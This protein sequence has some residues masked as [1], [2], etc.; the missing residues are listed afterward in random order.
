MAEQETQVTG[1]VKGQEGRDDRERF[2][3]LGFLKTYL[4]PVL[5]IF[6]IPGFSWWFF[7]YVQSDYDQEALESIKASLY[8][9]PNMPEEK[10]AAVLV[11]HE[12]MPLSKILSINDPVLDDFKSGINDSV[13]RDYFMFHWLIILSEICLYSGAGVF[14]IA[15]IA[16][17]LSFKSQ[18]IQYLSLSTGWHVLRFFSVLQV[19]GQ[20]CLALALSFWI[21]AFWFNMY[22]PK[23]I[24]IVGIFALCAIGLIIKA[25]FKKL[26]NDFIIKGVLLDDRRAEPLWRHIGRLADKLGTE[27]PQQIIAGID[28]NFFVTEQPVTV[29][30]RQ[31][32]GK[33][34]YLSLPLIKHM[35]KTEA[36]AVLAHELAHFSGRDTLYSKKISPLLG[37]YHYYLVALYE[38]GITRPVFSFMLFFRSLY[39]LSISQLSRSREYRADMLAAESTSPL[40]LAHALIK[41]SA[42]SNYRDKV[43]RGLFEKEH[44][45]HSLGIRELIAKGFESFVRTEISDSEINSTK[46]VHPFDSH[47]PIAQRI[48]AIGVES[49]SNYCEEILLK[50]VDDSWFNEIENAEE[51][52]NLQ[53]A[54]YEEAFSEYH[55][56]ALCYRFLPTTEAEKEIV[57]K[58]FPEVI[59]QT[60][61]D[62][63]LVINYESIHLTSWDSPVLYGSIKNCTKDNNY[64]D[65]GCTG[66][67]KRIKLSDLKGSQEEVLHMFEMYYGRYLQARSYQENKQKNHE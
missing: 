17:L 36:D 35:K 15:I 9:E 56:Q 16:V 50:P 40:D 25:I 29:E 5:M 53:W 12:K 37:R 2:T 39:Q 45:Q 32:F 65:I 31:Y 13:K 7:N 33:T 48:Q 66:G 26:D 55:E 4:M 20:G 58:H 1:E 49:T 63:Q 44:V 67:L 34:L 52:E 18:Q 23:I 60:K 46:I 14:A 11:F 22:V 21:T 54:E 47:P 8:N 19:V 38:G 59:I 57:T 62:E 41:V 3:K 27:R 51:L 43:E 61:K 6:L 30:G 64:L 28:D 10:R 42:Y 24:I